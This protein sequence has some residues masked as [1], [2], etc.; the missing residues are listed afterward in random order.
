MNIHE[1]EARLRAHLGQPGWP[2]SPQD[3]VADWSKLARLVDDIQRE[4]DLLGT[5]PEKYPRHVELIIRFVHALLPWYTRPLR[6]FGGDCASA[7]NELLKHVSEIAR[8][9]NKILARLDRVERSL[10]DVGR[11]AP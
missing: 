2:E 8:N 6:A 7:L 11:Q 1:L 3:K 5:I 9:Q 4:A 10:Q